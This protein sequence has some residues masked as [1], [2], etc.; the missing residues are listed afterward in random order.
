MYV[1]GVSVF[2]LF[3]GT[4]YA[5]IGNYTHAQIVAGMN[6]IFDVVDM[7]N[8]SFIEDSELTN[9]WLR[10]DADH[11]GYVT[12]A[13][14]KNSANAKREFWAIVF[15]E[16]DRDGDGFI[17]LDTIYGEYA[18]MDTNDDNRVSRLEFDNFYA[19]MM[20]DAYKHYGFL[21]IG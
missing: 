7:N 20:E 1:T 12:E 14:Y 19:T 13:E 10:V 5:D 18:M 21:L 9:A 15:Q 17:G 8:D 2:L 11:D 16:M 4:T 3:L 6:P